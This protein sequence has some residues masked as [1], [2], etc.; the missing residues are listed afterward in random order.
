[1]SPGAGRDAPGATDAGAG[2]REANGAAREGAAGIAAALTEISER[3]TLLIHEE[4]ELA[5]AEVT[6]KVT[7]IVRGAVVSV[8]AGV[9]IV[10]AVMFALVGGAWLLYFYLPVG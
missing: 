9:F 7:R 4:I 1:M 3:A 5:K 8:V 6:E 2:A 10:T